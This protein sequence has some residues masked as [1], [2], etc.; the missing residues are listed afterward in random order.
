MAVINIAPIEL[1]VFVAIF[2]RALRYFNVSIALQ[3]SAL[4]TVGP[5][6]HY[7]NACGN[8][9]STMGTVRA[10]DVSTAAAKPFVDEP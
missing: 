7:R 8:T 9:G 6:S 10:V 2:R 4:A 1:K 5:E 3:V